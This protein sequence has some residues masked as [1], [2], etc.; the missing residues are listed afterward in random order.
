MD[1]FGV[2]Q[3]QLLYFL[4]ADAEKET[5]NYVLREM[6]EVLGKEMPEADAVRAY[7]QDPD[8]ATTLST[9]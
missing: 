4:T 2:R 7:L 9:E 1:L 5:L 6:R 3:K 8:K